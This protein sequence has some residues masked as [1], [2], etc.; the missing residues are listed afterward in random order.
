M[1]LAPNVMLYTQ[2]Q[3]PTGMNIRAVRFADEMYTENYL[4]VC[5][6]EAA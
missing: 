4:G 5:N 3:V 1:L 2:I 6:F